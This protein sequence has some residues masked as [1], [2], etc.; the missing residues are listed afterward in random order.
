MTT[1]GA[2]QPIS[3]SAQVDLDDSFREQ[4]RQDQEMA[5]TA[6]NDALVVFTPTHFPQIRSILG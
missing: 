3:G 4:S 1:F 2:F 5:L 6:A